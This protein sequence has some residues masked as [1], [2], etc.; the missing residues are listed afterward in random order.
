MKEDWVSESMADAINRKSYFFS[1]LEKSYDTKVQGTHFLL[2][3]RKARNFGTGPRSETG[4]LP[5]AGHQGYAQLLYNISHQWGKGGWTGAA[6]DAGVRDGA[7]IDMVRDEM[8]GA[9]KDVS[10]DLNRQIYGDGTGAIATLA[11]TT[12][13]STTQT[14]TSTR[15][16]E[17]GMP[18]V[19]AKADGTGASAQVNITTIDPVT[20]II[21]IDAAVQTNTGPMTNVFPNGV[22]SSVADAATN[23]LAGLGLVFSTANYAGLTARATTDAWSVPTINSGASGLTLD[24]MI[25]TEQDMDTAANGQLALV[26]TNKK[27][28]RAYGNLIAPDRRWVNNIQKLDGGF[29]ALDFNG[30]PVV[31]DIDCPEGNMY[32]LDMDTWLW[33]VETDLGVVDRD[34]NTLRWLGSMPAATG[35]SFGTDAYEFACLTRAQLGCRNPKANA[36]INLLP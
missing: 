11:S 2:P 25:Q 16:L 8:Q 26:V 4:V 14:V 9:V 12:A 28:W 36:L 13:S 22:T 32:F 34:G 20:G 3:V 24:L 10:K 21:T 6:M 23:A 5:S 15:N 1:K 33:M 30:V 17:V 7:V 27:Q 35:T 29:N 19:F 18:I 31:Y